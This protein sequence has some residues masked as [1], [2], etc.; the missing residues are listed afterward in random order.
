MADVTNTRNRSDNDLDSDVPQ[1]KKRATRHRS[2]G[3]TEADPEAADSASD[4]KGIGRQF[5]LR[6]S[7]WLLDG[8]RTFK[9]KPDPNF[10]PTERFD[11]IENQ[12]Q[13][14]LHDIMECT[15][16]K[17]HSQ[18]SETWFGKEVSMLVHWLGKTTD[19]VKF[20]DGLS[21]QLSHTSTRLRGEATV[22]IF[23]ELAKTMQSS[24]TRKANKKCLGYSEDENGCGR[25]STLNIPILHGTYTGEYDPRQI[26]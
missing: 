26:F 15:P 6:Y 13:G 21:S 8:K 12:I 23:G 17:Y 25:W 9:T 3:G 19:L 10:D 11:S 2:L 7:L 22:A 1:P 24:D 20:T 18:L 5:A 4:I 16:S 14:Q